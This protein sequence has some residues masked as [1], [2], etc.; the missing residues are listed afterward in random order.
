M[1]K[2]LFESMPGIQVYGIAVLILFMIL[3][4]VIIFRI[5]RTDKQYLKKM[6]E[7]PLDHGVKNGEEKHDGT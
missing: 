1:L 2:N 6:S 5:M 7:L 3:F 4:I